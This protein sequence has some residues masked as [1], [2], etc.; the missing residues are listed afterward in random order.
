VIGH[1]SPDFA[2][3]GSLFCRGNVQNQFG[4]ELSLGATTP[5]E[6]ASLTKTWRRSTRS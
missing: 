1:A 3:S 6:I 5:F 4:T 2:N